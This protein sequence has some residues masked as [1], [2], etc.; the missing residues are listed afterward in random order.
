MTLLQWAQLVS[1][2]ILAIVAILGAA[3]YLTSRYRKAADAERERYITALEDRNKLLEAE[4]SQKDKDIQELRCEI[5]E[6]K[7]RFGTLQDLV[8]RRCPS[9][10]PDPD[11]GGCRFCSKGLQYG[12]AGA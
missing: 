3:L 2:V 8:L 7:G 10:E 11:T 4:N 6:L 5:R 1:Y 9:A 12:K